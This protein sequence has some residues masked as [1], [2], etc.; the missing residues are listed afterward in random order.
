MTKETFQTRPNWFHRI[1]DHFPHIASITDAA[2]PRSEDDRTCLQHYTIFLIIGLPI[3]VCYGLYAI[4][5]NDYRLVGYIFIS[6]GCVTSGWYLLHRL[7]NGSMVCR[8]S[9]AI[10]AVSIIYMCQTGGSDGSKILW[11]YIF[12]LLAFS[13]FGKK[14]GLIWSA[15]I[16]LAA[17]VIFWRPIPFIPAYEYGGELKIRFITTY[18]IV[19]LLTF[20]F[21]HTRHHFRIDK[22]VLKTRVDERTAELVQ[23]NQRLHQTIEN[24]NQL[25]ERAQAANRAKSDFI[26]TMSHEIRT[27]M[28][29]ILGLSH[30]ALE[31]HRLDD[32]TKDYLRGVHASAISLLG[33][34][35]DI[36][37]FSKIEAHKLYLEEMNFNL[38]EVLGNVANMLGGKAVEKN[39][40]LLFYYSSDIPVHLIGDPLRLGQIFINLVSNAI[41]FTQ[42]G[43]IVLFI[44][45]IEKRQASVCLEFNVRDTGIGL[46]QNQ[47]ELLFEPF[48][49]AD[50]STTRRFGGSGLG[51][52]ICSRL[53]KL[54]G[55]QIKAES[56]NANGSTFTFTGC[57]GLS[58]DTDNSPYRTFYQDF[59]G[60]RV[61]VVDGHSTGRAVLGHMLN[62]LG[63]D[64]ITAGSIEEAHFELVNLRQDG[65][66]PEL[67][68]MDRKVSDF[69]RHG[70]I[71]DVKNIE[72]I[73]IIIVAP[74]VENIDG[75]NL[76]KQADKILE[77]PVLFSSLTSRILECLGPPMQKRSTL[78]TGS[79][80]EDI[81]L[82]EFKGL[83]V[84]IV[85]D[86]EIN[87]KIACEFLRK[88]GCRVTVADNGRKALTRLNQASF[89]MVLMD[90]QMPEM[91]GLE[92]T[93]SIRAD[94][95]FENLPIIAMTAHA[96][97]QDREKCFEAGMNDYLSKPITPRRLYAIMS[98]WLPVNQGKGAAPPTQSQSD[99]AGSDPGIHLPDFDVD[100]ALDKSVG[101]KAK[102]GHIVNWDELNKAIGQLADLLDQGRLDAADRFAE[103]KEMMPREYQRDEFC[104]LADAVRRLDYKNARKALDNWSNSLK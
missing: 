45:L 82:D 13:F 10:F 85:E 14:E 96:M 47:I 59:A 81:N 31:N 1:L 29:S 55:G 26:A 6:S 79:G 7:A 69:D 60:K 99:D 24:S 21:E 48:T 9:S 23:L 28:N 2:P 103:F 4:S 12:P 73:P 84:L 65:L 101:N 66:R 61:L 104:I 62:A 72:S 30:L 19:S 77:K 42:T 71:H 91:D 56:R 33:I 70:F 63:F 18:C 8:V 34:I 86:K 27:P 68:I 88:K 97:A 36:L 38:E 89:D 43:E 102:A 40:E 51:L 95:R 74:Q 39:L 93:R 20:W 17:L 100:Q 78:E 76:L 32:R 53:A 83:K 16:L 75:N 41:K 3:M 11:F 87:Q 58:S 54:M 94:E 22:K 49:Q 35:D 67:I 44:K 25:A 98:G 52:A 15:A 64:V 37:D 92:A 5:Q 46:T 80:D 90:I 50:S 57:F